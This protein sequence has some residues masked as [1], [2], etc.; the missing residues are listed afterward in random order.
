[1]ANARNEAAASERRV[2]RGLYR[3]ASGRM[4]VE[5]VLKAVEKEDNGV[6]FMETLAMIDGMNSKNVAS[7]PHGP[8]SAVVSSGDG[9][10]SSPAFSATVGGEF[11]DSHAANAEEVA[12]LKK[13]LQD[14]QVIAETRDKMITEVSA[15]NFPECPYF[16]QRRTSD[17]IGFGLYLLLSAWSRKRTAA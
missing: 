7:S 5:E 10:M 11:K 14:V 15:N 13:R 2:R 4:T 16:F 9:A 12:Q 3:L 8:T 6:S 1:M 17:T